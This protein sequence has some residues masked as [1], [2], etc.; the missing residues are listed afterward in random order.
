MELVSDIGVTLGILTFASMMRLELALVSMVQDLPSLS[1]IKNSLQD[2]V[3]R[4]V[5]KRSN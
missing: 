4:K 3:S 2:G 1:S 5:T